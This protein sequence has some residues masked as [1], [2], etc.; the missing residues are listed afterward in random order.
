[1]DDKPWLGPLRIVDVDGKRELQGACLCGPQ[2][3]R[4]HLSS[5]IFWLDIEGG[6]VSLEKARE[7]RDKITEVLALLEG[8]E[9]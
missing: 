1:M 7:I 6:A 3:V 8:L 4:P 5:N 2:L 9:Q